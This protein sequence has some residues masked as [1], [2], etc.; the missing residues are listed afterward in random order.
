MYQSVGNSTRKK[1]RNWVFD[2]VF[3]LIGFLDSD[4][5]QTGSSSLKGLRAQFKSSYIEMTDQSDTKTITTATETD[6][7]SICKKAEGAFNG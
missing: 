2:S 1:F 4:K 6:E 5:S 7:R 3:C